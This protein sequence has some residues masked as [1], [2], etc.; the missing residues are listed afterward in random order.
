[1]ASFQQREDVV[2]HL[3]E[4]HV[5]AGRGARSARRPWGAEARDVGPATPGQAQVLPARPLGRRKPERGAREAGRGPGLGRAEAEAT[6]ARQGLG[7]L[8]GR[9]TLGA[10][11]RVLPGIWP[12]VLQL[13][14]CS[15][16]PGKCLTP[17]SHQPCTEG[18]GEENCHGGRGWHAQASHSSS[19]SS[20]TITGPLSSSNLLR[21]ERGFEIQTPRISVF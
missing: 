12:W 6:A 2:H 3:T 11:T 16:T 5:P 21:T 4:P 1:M 15:V 14:C 8:A 17:L 9:H 18:E 10:P 20:V 19:D 13:T 7:R